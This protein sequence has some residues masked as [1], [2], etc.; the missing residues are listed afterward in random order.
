M[1]QDHPRL[2]LIINADGLSSKQPF[3]TEVNQVGYNYILVAKPVDH[4]YMMEWID[5][6]DSIPH[7]SFVDTK[8]RRHEYEWVEDIPLNGREDSIR[9]NFFRYRIISIDKDGK[10]KNARFGRCSSKN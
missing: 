4:K 7:K 6:F 3:I 10:E 1:K 2:N 9:V 5:A 8:G